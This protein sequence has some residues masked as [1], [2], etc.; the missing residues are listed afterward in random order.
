MNRIFKPAHMVM[1]VLLVSTLSLRAAPA[2]TSGSEKDI[3]DIAK[4]IYPSVVRV[5]AKNHMRRV[6]T[7]VVIDKDGYVVTTALMSPR[8]EK[9]TITT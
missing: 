7:G 2:G 4:R 1:A 3:A 9:I 5:E 6:A 8:N